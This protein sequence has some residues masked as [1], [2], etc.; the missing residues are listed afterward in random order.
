MPL[1]TATYIA[2]LVPTNPVG[3]SDPKSQGDN[4][5]RLIKAVLQATFPNADGPIQFASTA[6]KTVDYTVVADDTNALMIGDATAAVVTFALPAVATSDGMVIGFKK[7]DSTA[8]AVILDPNGS[9]TIEGAAQVVLGEQYD[10]VWLWCDGSAWWVISRANKP[11]GRGGI[12]GL[13]LSNNVADATNDID[14]AVGRARD[15][16]DSDTMILASALTKRLDA[17]WAV[18]TGAG[19][20]DTGVISNA[21]WNI[22]LIKRIDTGVVDILASLSATAPTMP[23]GYTLFRRIGAILR[24]AAA[25]VAFTQQEEEFLWKAPTAATTNNPG[26]SAVTPTIAAPPGSVATV[27]VHLTDTS[28]DSSGTQMNI[29][30]TDQTDV[31]ATSM[32]NMDIQANNEVGQ[33]VFQLRVSSTSTIRYRLSE[34][35]ANIDVR[36]MVLGWR[37]TRNR[38]A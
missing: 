38:F 7:S 30:A 15:S 25:L 19:M 10:C 18:G 34:T 26:T 22:F 16:T 17:T 11:L 23:T 14:V 27:V 31:A 37:D 1:E 29:T 20:C 33:G 36:L 21:W 12:S 8:H 4:H 3:A 9:E 35:S 5:L 24:S 13:T 28:I 32:W 6:T 2:D